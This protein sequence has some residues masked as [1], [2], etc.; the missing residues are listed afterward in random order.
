MLF[1]PFIL[2]EIIT[3]TALVAWLLLRIVRFEHSIKNI[4]GRQSFSCGIGFSI[5][6]AAPRSKHSSINEIFRIRTKPLKP[7][8]IGAAYLP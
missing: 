7:S 8:D 6:P 2:N 5:P 3:P 4:I 1:W